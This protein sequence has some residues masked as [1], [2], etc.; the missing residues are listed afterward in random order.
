MTNTFS[1]AK[2]YPKE[3]HLGFITACIPLSSISKTPISSVAPD[4]TQLLLRILDPAL[5]TPIIILKSLVPQPTDQHCVS[6]IVKHVFTTDV[7]TGSKV[8]KI[9]ACSAE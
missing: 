1:T 4:Y 2:R 9:Q 6:K 3:P 8:H 7:G 5:I